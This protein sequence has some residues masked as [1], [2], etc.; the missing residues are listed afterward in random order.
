MRSKRKTQVL[1]FNYLYKFFLLFSGLL[2]ISSVQAQTDEKISIGMQLVCA[3]I[4]HYSPSGEELSYSNYWDKL[5][6]DG[7]GNYNT[8]LIGKMGKKEGTYSIDPSS[9][10]ITFTGILGSMEN[11]CTFSGR[12]ENGYGKMENEYKLI[13]IESDGTKHICNCIVM[14]REKNSG[15][16]PGMPA[17]A[18]GLSGIF[19]Y[20]TPDLYDPLTGL[21]LT[22]SKYYYFMKDGYVHEGLPKGG[23]ENCNC[24]ETKYMKNCKTY[25]IVN[26]QIEISGEQPQQFSKKGKDIVIG[27]RTYWQVTK[28]NAAE[29]KGYYKFMWSVTGGVHQTFWTFNA[30][31]NF[32]QTAVGTTNVPAIFGIRIDKSVKELNGTYQLKDYTL[33]LTY[34]NGGKRDHTLVHTFGDKDEITID[35]NECFR[36]KA[37]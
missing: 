23:I 32:Q 16:L 20:W 35:G 10:I 36:M 28:V 29:L 5:S 26:N 4:S 11:T 27:D 25:R 6:T 2:S 31:G 17:N 14:G 33:T 19:Y 24:K 13:L 34:S 7:W 15:K 22:D 21:N 12:R 37:K 1:I 18:G 30:N 8:G 9:G 3:R